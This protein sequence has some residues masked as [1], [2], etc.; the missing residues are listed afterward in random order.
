MFTK[1]S[2]VVR[3]WVD[4]IKKGEK[5]IEEVPALSNLIDVVSNIINEGD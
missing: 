4:A 1:N 5:S 2:I 3:T